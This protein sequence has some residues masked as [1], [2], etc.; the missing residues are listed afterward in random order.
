M[1]ENSILHLQLFK[2]VIG[3]KPVPTVPQVTS[4]SII[5]AIGLAKPTP[6]NMAWLLTKE[7]RVRVKIKAG[8]TVSCQGT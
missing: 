4:Q 2:A 6:F 3:F 1:R 8:P 7:V 5:L